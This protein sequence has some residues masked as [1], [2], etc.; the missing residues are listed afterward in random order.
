M[1][2]PV[3]ASD[4][5]QLLSTLS[6]ARRPRALMPDVSKVIRLGPEAHALG[7]VI[8]A[9]QPAQGAVVA[10]VLPSSLA[11]PGMTPLVPRPPGG[12]SGLPASHLASILEMV[13]R[14]SRLRRRRRRAAAA[15]RAVA[16]Q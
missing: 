9:P 12:V 7:K 2:T 11:A 3:G 5:Q 13:K 14:S 15:R 6:P 8:A 16:R 1:N 4:L 10:G